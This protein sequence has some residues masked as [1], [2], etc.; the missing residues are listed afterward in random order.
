MDVTLKAG[1]TLK[2]R[3]DR[4]S[5]FRVNDCVRRGAR[6]RAARGKRARHAIGLIE[7]TTPSV[8]KSHSTIAACGIESTLPLRRHLAAAHPSSS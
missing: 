8:L 7:Y 5:N 1:E 3:P 4:R 6:R 2:Q